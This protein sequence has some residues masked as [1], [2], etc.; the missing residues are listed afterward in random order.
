MEFL[1]N[2]FLG[3][4]GDFLSDL[5]ICALAIIVPLLLFAIQSGRVRRIKIHH[6][7]MLA[8]Y[9]TVVAYVI[10]YEVNMLAKGGMEFLEA[11][12]RM[13]KNIYWI[14]T[15]FHVL[16]GAITLI[17]GGIT[18]R[19]GMRAQASVLNLEVKKRHRKTGWTTFFLLFFTSV[20]G[21]VVYY[22]TFVYG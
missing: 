11:N 19:L 22:L 8:I 13:D 15:G 3:T 14:V 21:L 9:Y 5:L 7:V 20:T 12:V 17:L 1:K 16:L 10:V 6:T 2:G 4:R 18:I